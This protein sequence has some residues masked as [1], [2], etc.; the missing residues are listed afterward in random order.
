M[1]QVLVSGSNGNGQ[2]GLSHR[3]DIF[4][5]ECCFESDDK[6]IDI[7]CG[8]NHSIILTDKGNAYITG[9]KS[10]HLS[11][12]LDRKEDGRLVSNDGD[13]GNFTK[14]TK[15]KGEFKCVGAGWTFYV[16]VKVDNSIWIYDN[17]EMFEI[18]SKDEISET[19]SVCRIFTS[20]KSIIILLES[21]KLL[22]WGDN[23]KY[24]LMGDT[25]CDKSFKNIQ[26][27][28]EITFIDV[29]PN[30][31]L[32]CVKVLNVCM[33]RDYTVFRITYN[34]EEMI[35]MRC[36]TDRREILKGMD[37]IIN[38]NNGDNISGGQYTKF[39]IVPKG[40]SEVIDI[41]TMWSSIHIVLKN[42]N[43]DGLFIESIGNDVFGQLYKGIPGLDNN[44]D[45]GW[46]K[47]GTEHGLLVSRNKDRV[48]AWGWGEHGNCG[49]PDAKEGDNLQSVKGL[50]YSGETDK[51]V[52][53]YGGYA[54]TW[55]VVNK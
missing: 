34:N 2:L 52:D 13:D 27:V 4:E 23:S 16:F 37:S 15:I 1:Y 33:A 17:N 30:Y 6:P 41:D 19:D 12:I 45:I 9:C 47:A 22:C 11:D 48:Y 50:L 38:G 36:K 43:G 31:R 53:V 24:Q 40:P 49:R 18:M 51:I 26:N 39:I 21:G 25:G 44:K 42:K 29:L 28:T 10:N 32:E 55:V 8:S 35:I 3:E 54:N 20:L 14:F 46:I 5:L 7:A